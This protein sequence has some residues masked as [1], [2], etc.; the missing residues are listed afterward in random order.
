MA[1]IKEEARAAR[2]AKLDELHG[3][4]TGAVETLVTGAD[5]VRALAF[6]ARFRSRS[7]NNTLL[8]WAQHEAAFQAG[9][10]PVNRPGS[11]GGSQSWERDDE[12]HGSTEE[13]Q[14]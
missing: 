2:D 4:L 5:W 14:R 10:V 13:V 6:A 7:F 8:I 3:R 11:D 1:A 9:R 12:C